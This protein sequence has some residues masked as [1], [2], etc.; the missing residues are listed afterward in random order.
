MWRSV[1]GLLLQQLLLQL[2]YATCKRVGLT[3]ARLV[4]A[5]QLLSN[6]HVAWSGCTALWIE[7]QVLQVR[8]QCP[9]VVR[10]VGA[11]SSVRQKF[12]WSLDGPN[13]V[14]WHRRECVVSKICVTVDA[15]IPRTVLLVKE[16]FMHQPCRP[17]SCVM[18]A[19][20]HRRPGQPELAIAAEFAGT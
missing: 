20:F 1:D 19:E 10:R 9:H 16:H 13:V 5:W 8:W 18:L 4:A 17:R 6:G 3:R 15:Y 12:A 7:C 2:G 11:A 14:R